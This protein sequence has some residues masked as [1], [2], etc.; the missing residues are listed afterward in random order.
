MSKLLTAFA[1][2]I[3]FFCFSASVAAQE[4]SSLI[5]RIERVRKKQEPQRQL[6][7]ALDTPAGGDSDISELLWL[8]WDWGKT[9][10][11]A[12]ILLLSTEQSAAKWMSYFA[13]KDKAHAA[14]KLSCLG[15]DNYVVSLQGVDYV[16]KGSGYGGAV[17]R[18]GKA[19]VSVDS[20]SADQSVRFAML[21]DRQLPPHNNAMQP[22]A[23]QRNCHR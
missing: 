6:I 1:T 23:N 16:S 19:L 15:E 3:I 22:T 2:I 14:N 10:V 9:R 21:I 5:R 11:D 7:R 20:V 17:F 12:H 13:E 8:Q 4:G 18:R